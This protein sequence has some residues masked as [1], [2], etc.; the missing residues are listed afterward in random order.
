MLIL[1]LPMIA[2]WAASCCGPVL[3]EPAPADLEVIAPTARPVVDE[4]PPVGRMRCPPFAKAGR[5]R[6]CNASRL[7]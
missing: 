4:W 2:L 7:T 1:D 3:S 6:I 5:T